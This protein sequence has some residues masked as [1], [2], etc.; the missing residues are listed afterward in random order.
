MQGITETFMGS[1]GEFVVG[2]I[3][4]ELVVMGGYKCL[5]SGVAEVKRMR[6]APQLQG[7]GVG[8]WLLGQLEAR[9]AE[10]GIGDVVVSTLSVQ[11]AALK[12]YARAGYEETGRETLT[13][14]PETGFTVVSFAKSLRQS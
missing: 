3:N 14:G 13:E 9:M 7:R 4:E 11:S 6:V 8:P 12:L 10:A 1:G 5:S 2:H